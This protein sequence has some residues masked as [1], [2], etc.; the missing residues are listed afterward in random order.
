MIAPLLTPE[1]VLQMWDRLSGEGAIPFA[2]P[3]QALN[4]FANAPN[5]RADLT[6]LKREA[7][8]LEAK[9]VYPP[10]IQKYLDHLWESRVFETIFD[11]IGEKVAQMLNIPVLDQGQWEEH[12]L[13]TQNVMGILKSTQQVFCPLR[14]PIEVSC[15]G[16]QVTVGPVCVLAIRARHFSVLNSTR[17]LDVR[18]AMKGSGK[19]TNT[20]LR[21]LLMGGAVTP[22]N[23]AAIASSILTEQGLMGIPEITSIKEDPFM[24][25]EGGCDA[26][27]D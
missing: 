2:T 10:K 12:I 25:P 26:S 18:H 22:H 1:D 7:P 14:E 6:L 24:E 8:I 9:G 13:P 27:E 11:P 15:A 3:E 17:V 5:E 23:V 16:I 21:S 4:I 19:Y 20:K